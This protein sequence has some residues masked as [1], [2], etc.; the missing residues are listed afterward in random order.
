MIRDLERDTVRERTKAVNKS[1][2][3]RAGLSL[4]PVRNQLGNER[5]PLNIMSRL[6]VVVDLTWLCSC[7]LRLF[8]LFFFPYSIAV[9]AMLLKPH[10][11]S[12]IPPSP[13]NKKLG[14][15]KQDARSQNHGLT[16]GKSKSHMRASKAQQDTSHGCLAFLSCGRCRVNTA[17]RLIWSNDSCDIWEQQ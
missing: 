10:R 7:F 14:S 15:R 16:G 13:R 12:R 11:W 17:Q 1:S 8:F 2:T 9:R 6:L 5:C 4:P 3:T